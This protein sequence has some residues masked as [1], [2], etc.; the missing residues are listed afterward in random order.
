MAP[1]TGSDCCVE[2]KFGTVAGEK[3]WLCFLGILVISHSTNYKGNGYN[4]SAQRFLGSFGW[5]SVTLVIIGRCYSRQPLTNHNLVDKR[6]LWL[7]NGCLEYHRPIVTNP[8]PTK[9]SQKSLH[10]K[11]V[12]ILP[13]VS[14]V[15]NSHQKRPNGIPKTGPQCNSRLNWLSFKGN[16]KNGLLKNTVFSTFLGQKPSFNWSKMSPPTGIFFVFRCSLNCLLLLLKDWE[17]SPFRQEN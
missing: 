13:R 3:F 11:L 7:V 8:F 2:L 4:L 1:E 5:T 15:G 16:I 9:R 14:D 17:Y 12:P 6:Y 10:Q